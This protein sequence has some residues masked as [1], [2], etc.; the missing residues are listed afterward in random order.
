MT[1]EHTQHG[2]LGYPILLIIVAIVVAEAFVIEEF[3]AYMVWSFAFLV[4][5]GAIVVHFS[6]L[7]VTVDGDAVTV[8]FGYI[9]R[10]HRVI[11]FDAVIG[12]ERVRN[13]WW[14]GYGI[15]WIPGGLMYNVQGLDAIELTYTTGR[16]FRIGTD[17][18][19]GLYAALTTHIPT[20]GTL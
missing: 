9:G 5:I 19:D 8:A 17:D 16:K 14:Y 11:P 13:S 10:P 4:L 18:P 15:R 2:W 12:M 1:Y 6:R 3:A 7:K 20:A